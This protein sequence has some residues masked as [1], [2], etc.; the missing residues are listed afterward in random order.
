MELEVCPLGCW[1]RWF[2]RRS[3]TRSDTE[4]PEEGVGGAAR[5]Y[6]VLVARPWGVNFLTGGESV[7]LLQCLSR[8][9]LPKLNI[10]RVC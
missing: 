1:G 9:L 3:L 2:L 10:M 5:L 6:M 7:V 4:S 8:P